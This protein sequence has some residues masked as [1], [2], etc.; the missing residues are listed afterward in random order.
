MPFTMDPYL[1]DYPSPEGYS[2]FISSSEPMA[3][4]APVAPDYSDIDVAIQAMRARFDDRGYY[5]L[6]AA[7]ENDARYG[8]YSALSQNILAGLAG[9]SWGD[10]VKGLAAGSAAMDQ[11]NEQ[12]R[13]AASARNMAADKF[14]LDQQTQKTALETAKQD[15][16]T[17]KEEY[18][19]IKAARDAGKVA[20]AGVIADTELQIQSIIDPTI[21]AQATKKLKEM[22]YWVEALD[23]E[24]A[25]K[26]GDELGL[27]VPGIEEYNLRKVKELEA[28]Q[29]EGRETGQQ[30]VIDATNQKLVGQR[31]LIAGPDGKL[32]PATDLELR[33]FN[34]RQS[35]IDQQIRASQAQAGLDEARARQ[36]AFG[37]PLSSSFV[38]S[39]S[40][41]ISQA[42]GV[43]NAWVQKSKGKMST[44]FLAQ[45]DPALQSALVVLNQFQIPYDGRQVV[46]PGVVDLNKRIHE[47]YAAQDQMNMYAPQGGLS[48]VPVG[49]STAEQLIQRFPLTQLPGSSTNTSPQ[50]MARAILDAAKRSGELERMGINVMQV[51]AQLLQ[52]IEQV[53]ATRGQGR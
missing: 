40:K 2:E 21:K 10:V 30:R 48:Q 33:E 29:T 7:Q 27:L 37:K 1:G 11:T 42:L 44:D 18:E 13:A 12:A 14:V 46:Q 47:Y 24:K 22:K 38:A 35:L 15:Y 17:R 53:L 28:A 32:R 8:G 45:Q 43:Y 25:S 5:G 23:F 51:E 19:R 34:S 50:F 52:E 4:Y 6:T 39:E 26:A 16:K 20:F 36:A 3:P 41:R 9:G 31:N 49:A